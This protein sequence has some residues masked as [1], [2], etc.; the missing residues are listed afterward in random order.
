MTMLGFLRF[1]RVRLRISLRVMLVLVSFVCVGLA[2]ETNRV[3]TRRQILTTLFECS[4]A[5]VDGSVGW[6]VSGDSSDISQYYAWN[7]FSDAT[8][9][10][11]K[12][13]LSVTQRIMGDG[14]ILMLGVP[15]PQ[16]DHVPRPASVSRSESC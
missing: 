13:P 1:R 6:Y 2:H 3:R 4:D 8:Y 9:A 11:Q 15:E 14:K 5:A 10:R 12:A 16:I 7:T